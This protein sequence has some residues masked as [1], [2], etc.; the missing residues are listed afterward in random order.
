MK[1]IATS[2]SKS[3]LFG[4]ARVLFERNRQQWDYP[5]TKWQKLA[6]G[7]YMILRDYGDGK[8]PPKYDNEA[9]AHEAEEA[10]E[11]T[12][13][14]LGMDSKRLRGIELS[15]PFWNSPACAKYLRD[16]ARIQSAINRCGITPPAN[17]LEVGCYSGWA[18]EFLALAGF[19]V[20]ATDLHGEELVQSRIRSLAAKE[21]EGKLEFRRAAMEHLR[22]AFPSQ[23][24]DAVF[25]Y[26]SL[27]HAYDW[28]QAL[29]SFHDVLSPNGWCF[30][31]SEP[32][33]MH[34]FV[35]YRV[36]QLSNTHEIGMNARHIRKEL[37][38]IG[39]KKVV[40]LRN[41]LHGWVKP[42]WIA[43]QK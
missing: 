24:F 36:G 35:S 9:K 2:L 17:I 3:F 19:H 42:I 33:L 40:V 13:Q 25:V 6:V 23:S 14:T 5:L 27:H 11:K 41:R 1:K 39:F 31:C 37:R 12:L 18:S 10:T 8:F 43:A 29:Q 20:V 7:I 15:K 21:L 16:Y 34:T 26:E 22:E 30:I 28:R 38:Q 32:N 4:N